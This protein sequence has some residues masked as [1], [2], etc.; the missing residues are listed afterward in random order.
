MADT[1]DA[2]VKVNIYN[3]G[4][5]KDQIEFDIFTSR[6]NYISKGKELTVN[7]TPLHFINADRIFYT[8]ENELEILKR[9]P[10]QDATVP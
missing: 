3:Y 1:L 5:L 2:Q 10:N 4:P 8:D 9:E 7:W 6:L